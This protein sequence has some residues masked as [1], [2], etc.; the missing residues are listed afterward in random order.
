MK[1]THTLFSQELKKLEGLNLNIFAQHKDKESNWEN[2][3][4]QS[5]EKHF[6]KSEFGTQHASKIPARRSMQGIL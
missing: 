2:L 3:K 6:E 4:K 1:S 5:D